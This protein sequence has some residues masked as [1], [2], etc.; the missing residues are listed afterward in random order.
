MVGTMSRPYRS[1]PYRKK[2]NVVGKGLARVSASQV[3]RNL[4]KQVTRLTKMTRGLTPELKFADVSLTTSNITGG[5]SVL[6]NQV[7][8]GVTQA[9]RIGM[10]INMK[11]WYIAGSISTATTSFDLLGDYYWRCMVVVDSDAGTTAVANIGSLVVDQTETPVQ[12]LYNNLYLK[13]FK[14][15]YDSGPMLVNT[16]QATPGAEA[17]RTTFVRASGQLP[18]S[19]IKLNYDSTGASDIS[20]KAVYFLLFS[21][22]TVAGTK[23]LDFNGSSRIRFTD[24]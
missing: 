2:S 14:I 7:A 20:R 9:N 16:I 13:R 4:A 3:D 12:M 5:V 19:G 15:L 22:A 10:F 8:Q 11:S 18:G 1:R 6:M 23:S 17:T 21:D 24:V